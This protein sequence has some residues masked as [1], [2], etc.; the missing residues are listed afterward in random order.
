MNYQVN[1]RRHGVVI[2]V[3]LRDDGEL[4]AH[5]VEQSHDG[6]ESRLATLA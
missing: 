5:S 6:F 1:L 3:N 2:A 4:H